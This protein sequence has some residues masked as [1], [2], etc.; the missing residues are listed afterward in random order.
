[1]DAG[2]IPA[3]IDIMIKVSLF[4]SVWLADWGGME[5]DN[6]LQGGGDAS[7]EGGWMLLTCGLSVGR[8]QGPERS[9]MGHYKHGCWWQH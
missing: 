6:S 2:L 5:E 8:I 4:M 9:C 1:M 3:V 7:Q